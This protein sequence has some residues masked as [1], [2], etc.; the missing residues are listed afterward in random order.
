MF[1]KD[2]HRLLRWEVE[3]LEE[4]RGWKVVKNKKK[5]GNLEEKNQENEDKRTK[6]WWKSPAGI[7]KVGE[8]I[9][10]N[11][12]SWETRWIRRR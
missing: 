10:I 6:G 8:L 5:K 12:Q 4:N 2:C 7:G 1:V 3:L 9:K 11:W